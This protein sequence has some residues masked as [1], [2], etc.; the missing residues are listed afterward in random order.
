MCLWL[1]AGL[2]ETNRDNYIL[3][4]NVSLILCYELD[5]VHHRTFSPDIS[6]TI[7]FGCQ[8]SNYILRNVE[9]CCCNR[10]RWLKY[11][12]IY[13]SFTFNILTFQP[14]HNTWQSEGSTKLSPQPPHV[15]PADPPLCGLR[16]NQLGW[17]DRFSTG[18]QC[19]L[20]QE[21]LSVSTRKEFPCHE[22]RDCAVCHARSK[23]LQ[24]GGKRGSETV[25]RYGFVLNSFQKSWLNWKY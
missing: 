8:L 11:W 15:M 12:Y 24:W 10:Q 5:F 14:G 6:T 3:K 4:I 17:L 18:L 7:L 21:L 2:N 23:A 19:L 13:F 9:V 20:L 16:G 25:W 1:F 22:S